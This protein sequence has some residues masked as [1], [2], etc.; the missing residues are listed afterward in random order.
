MTPDTLQQT[1]DLSRYSSAELE[2]ALW[3]SGQLDYLLRGYQREV[4]RKIKD[5]LWRNGYGEPS[6]DQRRFI[7]EI[8][9]RW[10]KSFLVALLACELCIQKPGARVYWAA[11]T[12]K[13]V[14]KILRSVLRPLLLKCPAHLRPKWNSVDSCYEWPNGSEI[15]IGG[16]EDL[17][18]ADRLRGDGC[19][20]FVIDEAGSIALLEYVYKSIATFMALDRDG[21]VFMPSTPARTP[22]HPFTNYCMEAELGD[23]GYERHDI[24]S[25]NFTPKQIADL[26]H[27][28]GG[29]KSDDWQREALVQRVV[30]QARAIF[31]EFSDPAVE[32]ATLQPHCDVC[33]VHFDHHDATHAFK[34]GVEEPEHLDRYVAMDYGHHPDL[35]AIGFGYYDFKEALTVITHEAELAKPTSEDVARVVLAT[36]REAWGEAE[37]Y[38]RVSDTAPLLLHELRG[39]HGLEFQVTRKDDKEAAINDV[40]VSLRQRRFRIHP[41]C[42][43]LRL[44]MKAGLWNAKRTSYERLAGYGHFDFCD[45]LIYFKRSIDVYNDPYPAPIAKPLW[46]GRPESLV[47]N[48]M[49]PLASAFRS[50][51]RALFPSKRK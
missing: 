36:E 41:R 21:R 32:I 46:R 47:P 14:R 40:R 51:N 9:R 31:P 50:Q 34:W 3:V 15:H 23:G 30:D 29:E 39:K 20:L 37:P 10:G 6:P 38:R 16:C 2:A 8:C 42:K 28:L 26:A 45:M 13:Q 24:Y 11:E 17:E 19:D 49:Q 44:H 35:T 27:D 18:K 4:Y 43:K 1:V 22:A 12:S 25:A 33:G 7:L 48:H 5:A